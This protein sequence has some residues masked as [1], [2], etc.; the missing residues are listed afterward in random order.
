MNRSATAEKISSVVKT[1]QSIQIGGERKKRISSRELIRILQNLSTLV[2]NGVSLAQALDTIQADRGF[3]KSREILKSLSQTVRTG[4]SLSS[5]M[6]KFPETFSSLIIHQ[7]QIGEATGE[8]SAAL[9]KLVGQLENRSA[10]KSYLVKKLAYPCILVV[11]G[12][13]CVT[14]MLT[15]VIPT[16]QTM[17][18]ESGATLPWITQ[19]LVDLSSTCIEYGPMILLCVVGFVACILT[20]YWNRQMGTAIDRMLLKVPVLGNWLCNLGILQF[21]ETLSN[22]LDS[23][24]T[25]VD[26]LPGAARSVSNRYMRSRLLA[27]HASVRKGERFSAVIAHDQG[28]FPPVV[29]QLVIIGEKT[30][31][32]NDVTRQIHQHLKG[33]VEK[34]TSAL[35]AAIEPLLTTGLAFTIGGILL[36]VY[37]P[38]FDMIGSHSQ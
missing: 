35:L 27:V 28:L 36:A 2:N 5:G 31:R 29:R 4:S 17:Y 14:F 3:N 9:S 18:Q 25:L 22:L 21:S 19:F 37:L 8:I 10:L 16:F 38:M 34:I 13:A 26:A 6:R 23:G 30:G 24:F 1:L 32:L 15:Y 12:I 7:V 33:E 11:A 20:A